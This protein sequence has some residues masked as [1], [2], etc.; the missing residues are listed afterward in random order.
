MKKSESILKLEMLGLNTLDYFITKDQKEALHYLAKHADDLLSMRTERGV[1]EFQCPF[2]YMMK[3][4]T[5]I[6][7]ATGHLAQGYKLIFSPSLDT[8]GCLAFGTVGLGASAETI[9]E[10]VIGEGK[11]RELDNHPNK[12][13]LMIPS[14]AIIACR[15]RTE[16]DHAYILNGIYLRVKEACYG[17]M[18]CVVEWSY[19]DHSVGMKGTPDIYWEIRDYA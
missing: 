4:S 2:Y 19:Y 15:D 3:G 1:E 14:G 8:K 5:L 13:F 11:V 6:D 12:R 7:I 9:M 16:R 18:P 10:Y 17:E